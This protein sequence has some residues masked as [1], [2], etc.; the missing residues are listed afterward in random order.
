MAVIESSDP[1]VTALY[2]D[3]HGWLSGWLRKKL[4]NPADA[5]D[6][7][8]DTFVGLLTSRRPGPV[9]QPRAYL[10]AIAR[11]V[12]VNRY[13]RQALERAYLDTL[14]LLPEP[15]TP[16]PEH[17]L[18]LLQTLHEIDAMLDALPAA[19]KQAFLMSQL[20]GMT[21]D[22]IA[23]RLKVSLSTVKRYMKQAF[24][25]CLSLME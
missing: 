20:E 9:E 14:A 13:R 3:H 7:A 10:A 5:A 15:E 18:S 25:Q 21:Y 23:E 17:R 19:A 8:H 16:S 6:L 12:L 2:C 24:V 1:H 11:N 22:A 4:G